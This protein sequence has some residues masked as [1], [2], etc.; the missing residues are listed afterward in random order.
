VT[1][2]R[3]LDLAGAVDAALEAR[4]ARSGFRSA[5]GIQAVKGLDR[6]AVALDIAAAAPHILRQVYA[7]LREAGDAYLRTRPVARARRD[8]EAGYEEARSRLETH[9]A[10]ARGRRAAARDV[11][12]EMLGVPEHE[13]VDE[14]GPAN[15][16][17]ELAPPAVAPTEPAPALVPDDA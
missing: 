9:E 11:A 16:Q 1:E 8:A 4:A 14:L 17:R 6:D 2:H 10:Y 15:P 13:L 5:K 12:E 3:P 7:R